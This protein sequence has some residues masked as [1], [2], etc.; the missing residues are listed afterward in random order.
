MSEIASINSDSHIHID[1]S[2]QKIDNESYLKTQQA[3]YEEQRARDKQTL[4][5]QLTA[6]DYKGPSKDR[7]AR[8]A[9]IVAMHR[10]VI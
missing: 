1:N 3:L 7:T 5:N 9:A 10:V 2:Q 6:N 4:H 8:M